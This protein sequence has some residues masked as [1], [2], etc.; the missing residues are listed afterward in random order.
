MI[1]AR[2]QPGRRDAGMN[3]IDPQSLRADWSYPTRVRFGPGRIAELP[4][5]CRA[6]GIARPL[7][8]TDP[9]LAQHVIGHRVL[10]IARAAGLAVDLFADVRPIR[11]P[12]TSSRR[13]GAS[14]RRPRRRDRAR[15]RQRA[16]MPPRRSPS[17]P[18]QTRPIWDFEDRG[19]NWRRARPRDRAGGRDPDHRRHRLGGRA[20][21]GDHQPGDPYQMHRLPPADAARAGDRRPGAD[22]RAARAAHRLDRPRRALHSLEALCAPGFHPMADGIATEAI[23]LIHGASR[24]RRP[25]AMISRRAP[26]CWP[27]R[28]WA[29]WRSRRGSAPCTRSPT[30]SAACSTAITA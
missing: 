11:P 16:S 25:T 10:E 6:L 29:R 9:A 2:R 17:W 21:R 8:V 20:G 5:A 15:R 7:L 22:P 18:S 4:D 28:A 12:R 13:R 14:R 1:S 30:R 3:A 26:T 27:P 23:R 24:S 19:D